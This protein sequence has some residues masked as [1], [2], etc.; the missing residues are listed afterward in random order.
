MMFENVQHVIDELDE[1]NAEMPV[2][3]NEERYRVLLRAQAEIDMRFDD[4]YSA[5]ME[6]SK[7]QKRLLSR[8]EM[9]AFMSG[10]D[11]ARLRKKEKEEN[12]PICGDILHNGKCTSPSKH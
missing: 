8:L 3:F 4:S 12:C 6:Y 5:M 7:I 1:I 9:S 2:S 10:F 11:A